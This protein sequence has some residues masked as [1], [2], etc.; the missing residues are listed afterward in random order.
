MPSVL[1]L[2]DIRSNNSLKEQLSKTELEKQ[3]LEKQLDFQKKVEAKLRED[4]TEHRKDFDHLEKQFEHFAGL[5]A[6]YEELQQQLQL[7]RLE[8]LVDSGKSDDKSNDQ[9]DKAR[10]ELKQT[11]DELKELKKLDPHR[12]KR[13]VTDLK[14]KSATQAAENKNL[15]KALVS[16]RKELREMTTEKD[17][18]SR[19][20]E[21]CRK[22]LDY[23]WQSDDKEWVLY[24]TD[25]RLMAD[26]D[27]DNTI[28]TA[29]KCLHT[30]T[31]QTWLSR[32]TDADDMAVWM[33]EG[34][35]P[36]AVTIEAGKRHNKLAADAEEATE[37]T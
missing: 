21:A 2:K 6:E 13:Q 16:A 19:E 31:G 27:G 29:I 7:E 10:A 26:K 35:I 34:E 20:L 12:L 24:E 15:N 30:G 1:S 28:P 8:K 22:G 33:G 25:Q 17:K 32:E 5:E 14:K 4:L 18:L 11:Q 23:F 9:L 37:E 36:E 3:E